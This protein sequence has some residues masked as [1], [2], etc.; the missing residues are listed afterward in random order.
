MISRT[1]GRRYSKALLSLALEKNEVLV[2]LSRE[3]RE[4]SEALATGPGLMHFLTDPNVLLTDRSAALDKIL[5][6][7]STRPL[8]DNLS[9]LLLK[10][11]TLFLLAL[12]LVVII[13]YSNTLGSPFIFDSRNNIESN[14]HIRITEITR[15][16]G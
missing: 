13:I 6:N 10:Y 9:R 4:F 3:L 14:P 1:L 8:V 11:E 15:P 2:E 7:I 16:S 12:A 5:D